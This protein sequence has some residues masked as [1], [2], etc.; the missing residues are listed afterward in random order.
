[1][2]TLFHH[3]EARGLWTFA[4]SKVSNKGE[5]EGADLYQ[6]QQSACSSMGPGFQSSPSSAIID[7]G[8][9][10]GPSS[11]SQVQ[12]CAYSFLFPSTN[13]SRACT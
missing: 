11:A 13:I 10:L 6:P 4:Q 9:Y 8:Q 3:H 2:V 1:M 12:S 5:V 7:W